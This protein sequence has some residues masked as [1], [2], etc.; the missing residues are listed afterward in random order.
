M[1][2]FARLQLVG[3]VTYYLGWI[4]LLC[5][6]VAHLNIA[7]GLFLAMRLSQRNL[8]EV[9]VMCFL[10]CMASELRARD[11]AGA[12]V[13]NTVKGQAAAA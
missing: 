4:A 10:I 11:S 8:L 1:G 6:G 3:R 7:K 5:G 13:S 2:H 12:E 9:S